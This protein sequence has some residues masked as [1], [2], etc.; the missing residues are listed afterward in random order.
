MLG[1]LKGIYGW[2]CMFNCICLENFVCDNKIGECRCYVGWIG[3]KC[4]Y[5][6][7]L[8]SLVSGDIFCW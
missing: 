8:L 3:S 1:C 2:N 5:G 6:K 4:E 7:F